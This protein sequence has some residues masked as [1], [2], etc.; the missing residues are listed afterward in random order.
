[1]EY[2]LNRQISTIQK[3]LTSL[4]VESQALQKS[5][6][7]ADAVGGGEFEVGWWRQFGV[8]FY[9]LLQ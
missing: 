7:Q 5:H 4:V 1:M 8:H 9:Y 3:F 6:D 2:G